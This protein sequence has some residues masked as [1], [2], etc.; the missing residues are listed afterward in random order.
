MVSARARIEEAKF[1]ESPQTHLKVR[2]EGVVGKGV[3]REAQ[4][5]R[6]AK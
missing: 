1:P 3:R 6:M 4:L 2:V 5:L